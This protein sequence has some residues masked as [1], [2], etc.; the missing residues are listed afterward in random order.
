MIKIKGYQCAWTP[1]FLISI[2]TICQNISIWLENPCKTLECISTKYIENWFT[3]VVWDE[4]NR[5]FRNELYN[6]KIT[7]PLL[8][9]HVIYIYTYSCSIKKQH[10]IKPSNLFYTDHSLLL[11]TPGT[12]LPAVG[13][14]APV[15]KCAYSKT[16]CG[17]W[18]F[19]Q[20]DKTANFMCFQC[21]EFGPSR[22]AEGPF[23]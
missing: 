2:W 14:G 6:I 21:N 23:G 19:V 13:S 11:V 4:I 16:T 1:A 3:I 7:W 9:W 17:W 10:K 8:A 12:P 5:H 20:Q 18:N 15:R 22:P